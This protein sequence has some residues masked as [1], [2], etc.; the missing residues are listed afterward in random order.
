MTFIN[1]AMCAKESKEKTNNIKS[2]TEVIKK[3][4]DEGNKYDGYIE[5]ISF[6]NSAQNEGYEESLISNKDLKFIDMLTNKVLRDE[7]QGLVIRQVPGTNYSKLR[8]LILMIK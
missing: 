2:I 4:V 3:I 6:I 8:G 7:F 5:T 1:I